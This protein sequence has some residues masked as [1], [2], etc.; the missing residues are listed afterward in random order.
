MTFQVLDYKR[1]NFLDDDFL[2][3]K[4]IYTKGST[5]LN[6]FGH[7]NTLCIQ[8]NRAITNHTSIEEYYLRFF[9]RESFEYLCG[10]YPIK[11]RY[12]VF[13]NCKRYNK[14]WNSD[15]KSLKNFVAFLEFNLGPFS[16]YEEIT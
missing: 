6:Y 9:S 13:Y 1:N 11:S 15:K 16:F 4:P 12:H 7:S 14:F 2:S 5:W 10:N 8:A 3:T